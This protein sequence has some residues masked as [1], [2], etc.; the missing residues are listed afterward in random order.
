MLSIIIPTLNEEKYLPRLLENIKRQ[1][2]KDYEI[3][4]C[5]GYSYDQTAKIAQE[6]NCTLILEKKLGPAH[7]RNVG[8]RQAKGDLLLF[9]DADS[10]FSPHFISRA[11]K[12]FEARKLDGASFFIN[13]VGKK[14]KPLYHLYAGVYNLFVYLCQRFK[15]ISV[16]AALISTKKMF[17]SLNGFDETVY[18]GEDLEYTERIRKKG[19]YRV[20]PLRFVFSARRFEEE[21]DLVFIIKLLRVAAYS[22]FRGPLKKKIVAWDFGKHK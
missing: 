22:I 5:D 12:K 3:I 6:N 19:K 21:G 8:A 7:Q 11:I 14:N 9:L 17:D 20:L 16:G 18:V 15:A 10:A 2:Y 4:V 1:D 13:I